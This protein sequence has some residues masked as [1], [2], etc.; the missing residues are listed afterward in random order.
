MNDLWLFLGCILF[1]F[2]LWVY[3]GGPN[4]PISFSGP[5]ITP[6]TSPGSTQSGYGYGP[7][8]NT[9]FKSANTGSRSGN[10]NVID[11]ARS[12]FADDIRIGYSDPRARNARDEYMVVHLDSDKDI[13]ITGWQLVDADNGNHVIIPHGSRGSSSS[14]RDM[15]LSVD[16]RDAYIVSGSRSSDAVKNSID[17]A[18]HAYLG[19]NS[20]IWNDDSDTI[21]LLDQNGK[22]VDQYSY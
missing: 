12:P 16:Y 9:F 18:W 14:K 1:L 10:V 11:S 7:S 5:Y 17:G 15:T 8:A 20:D 22:V 19:K 2:V 21:T 13:D 4:N 3:A 6:I